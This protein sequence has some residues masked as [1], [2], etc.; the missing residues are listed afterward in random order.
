MPVSVL[1]KL[2]SA[3][4][5]YAAGGPCV[6]SWQGGEPLL[7]GLD[8]FQQAVSFQQKFGR[9][10][11]LVSNTIQTNGTLINAEWIEFFQKYHVFVGL[12]LDG[13]LRLH[14]LYR[15]DTSGNGSYQQVIGGWKWLKEGRVE[16]NVLSTMGRATR[17]NVSETVKFFLSRGINYLQ[18]IPAVDRSQGKVADFSITP[19]QYESFLCDLFDYWWNDGEP[20][21][22]VRFFDNILESLLGLKPAACTLQKECG[23]YLVVEANGD[24]YPCDFFVAGEWKLG[25]I[26]ETP[27]DVLFQKA[28]QDFG[29][30]K[31]LPGTDCEK[32]RYQFL[33]QNGCLWFRWVKSGSLTGRDYFCDAY[34]SFFDYALPRLEKLRDRIVRE[35]YRFQH[36][37]NF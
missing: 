37:E 21:F 6:F 8:F 35:K 4:M 2:V 34:Q 28:R 29:R 7:A 10:G 36:A 24:V 20:F 26:M 13:P 14:N 15:K 19:G 1:E 22:S 30:Y 18:F 33:C 12:S 27:L 11:Q 23:C 17:H 31:S 9:P 16:F 32:C 3:T 5:D 25:N